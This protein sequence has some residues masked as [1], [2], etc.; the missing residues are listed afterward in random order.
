MGRKLA[1][2]GRWLPR[3]DRFS[4]GRHRHESGW[5]T[6]VGTDLLAAMIE[7]AERTRAYRALRKRR[8]LP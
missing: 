4:Y 8:T 3:R 7:N 2:F 5:D 1:W 6:K